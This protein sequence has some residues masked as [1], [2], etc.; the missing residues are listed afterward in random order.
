MT[1]LPG[2]KDSLV[3]AARQRYADAEAPQPG[4]QK[5]R[6][7]PRW[8]TAGGV[9]TALAAGTAIA[10][11][12]VAVLTLGHR[13]APTGAAAS[14]RV[15]RAEL[16]RSAA[17]ALAR[18]TLPPGAALS[19]L[20]RGTPAQLWSPSSRLGIPGGVD[21]YRVWRLHERA[22]RVIQFI[23]SHEPSLGGLG[24]GFEYEAGASGPGG[25][26]MVVAASGSVDLPRSARGIWRQLALN[27]AAL[28]GGWTALR[29]DS[30]AGWLAPRPSNE[31]IPQGITQ[32]EF[33]WNLRNPSRGGS[34]TITKPARVDGLVSAVNSLQAGAGTCNTAP[35]GFITLAF[36][37]ANRKAPLAVATWDPPCRNLELIIPGRPSVSLMSGS[38]TSPVGAQFYAQ[39]DEELLR[40]FRPRRVSSSP[41][42][43]NS[44]QRCASSTSSAPAL[45]GSAPGAAGASCTSESRST[46][47]A[48]A[49]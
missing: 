31:L 37:A 42:T 4:P 47:S 10:V 34:A 28:G 2:L 33:K 11:A 21:V 13:P 16:R 35:N 1:Y 24:G 43:L 36:G 30:E 38:P 14:T 19:G 45:S 5:P 25:R 23:E 27:A 26:S 41:T 32:I 29:V 9:A 12:A 7:R 6:R 8:L 46:T 40:L 48:S 49:P 18:L 22:D 17:H 3:A 15:T 39:M 44:S 20:V